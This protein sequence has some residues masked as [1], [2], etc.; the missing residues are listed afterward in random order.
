[1]RKTESAINTSVHNKYTRNDPLLQPDLLFFVSEI[2][3]TLPND[4]LGQNATNK[5]KYIIVFYVAFRRDTS[6][7]CTRDHYLVFSGHLLSYKMEST[8]ISSASRSKPYTSCLSM[9]EECIEITYRIPMHVS[10]IRVF[11]RGTTY[12]VCPRCRI[13]L[14]REYMA[15]CDTCGQKLDWNCFENAEIIEVPL[16]KGLCG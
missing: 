16:R 13:S 2:L 4:K 1:M 15:F 10:D 5:L 11:Q 8:V 3:L 9:E 7:F 14:D 6:F 12:A